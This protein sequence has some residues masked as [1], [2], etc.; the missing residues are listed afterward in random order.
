MY[1]PVRVSILSLSPIS[2]NNGTAT[3]APVSTIA[4]LVAPCAVFPLN[5]GSVSVT[6]SSTVSGGSI[7][8]GFSLYELTVTSSFSF[9]NLRESP[10]SS[11]FQ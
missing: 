9:T 1:S 11:V 4:G 2:T 3:C 7:A 6:S 10:T 8:N 5:P